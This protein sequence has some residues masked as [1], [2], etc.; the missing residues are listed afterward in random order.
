[1]WWLCVAPTRSAAAEHPASPECGISTTTRQIVRHELIGFFEQP[2]SAVWNWGSNHLNELWFIGPRFTSLIIG[3]LTT[4]YYA[5]RSP[6]LELHCLWSFTV[7]CTWCPTCHLQMHTL[8]VLL[9]HNALLQSTIYDT[10]CHTASFQL[11]ASF[12][13]CLHHG[14]AGVMTKD[15]WVGKY[16]TASMKGGRSRHAEYSANSRSLST[17]DQCDHWV[18][19]VA[20]NDHD[21]CSRISYLSE[22]KISECG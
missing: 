3:L 1:M 10:F 11:H 19:S 7:H 22:N 5:G 4:Y 21:E 2:V 13:C 20:G 15:T 17:S 14:T 9:D 6:Q 12:P 16:F 8:S 18:L